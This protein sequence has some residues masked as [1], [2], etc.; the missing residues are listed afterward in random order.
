MNVKGRRNIVKDPTDLKDKVQLSLTPGQP[1]F[2]KFGVLKG[3]CLLYR[4]PQQVIGRECSP[5]QDERRQEEVEVCC[6]FQ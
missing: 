6:A 2:P 1:P 4:M 3:S 5:R